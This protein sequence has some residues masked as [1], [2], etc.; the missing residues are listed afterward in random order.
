MKKLVFLTLFLLSSLAFASEV[1]DKRVFPQYCSN[2][3]YGNIPVSFSFSNCV[4]NNFNS[5]SRELNNRIYLSY[6][7]NFG[8][9]VQYSYVSCIN[10]NFQRIAR[11]LNINYM[12]YC[13]NFSN[14]ELSYSF[15]SCVNRNNDEIAWTLNNRRDD[16]Q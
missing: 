2:Y 11:H 1:E 6:C 12:S 7:S 14:N 9:T 8:S 4:N 10:N 5:F 15:Q 3:S 13:N 16:D